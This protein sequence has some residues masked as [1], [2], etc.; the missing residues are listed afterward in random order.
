MKKGFEIT[1]N[2]EHF[3]ACIEPLGKL[4]LILLSTDDI[5]DL[6]IKGDDLHGKIKCKFEDLNCGNTVKIAVV[7]EQNSVDGFNL[8]KEKSDLELLQ[9]Y[10]ELKKKF[11]KREQ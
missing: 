11:Y 6:T 4:S 3:V 10:Y 8:Y 1:I 2:E 9:E 5:T 7:E